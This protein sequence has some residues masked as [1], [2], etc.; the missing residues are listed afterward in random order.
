MAFQ[1]LEYIKYTEEYSNECLAEQCT[2]FTEL[3]NALDNLKNKI[4]DVSYND[5]KKVRWVVNKF[6]FPYNPSII[7]RAFYKFWEILHAFDIPVSGTN[8]YCA[9]APGGFIQAS[10]LYNEKIQSTTSNDTD[11]V[12]VPVKRK[13]WNYTISLDSKSY[14]KRIRQYTT[15]MNGKGDIIDLTNISN[16]ISRSNSKFSMIT[17]DGG[18]DDFFITFNKENSHRLLIYTEVLYALKLQKTNGYFI[19]KFFDTITMSS[20]HVLY[21]LTQVYSEVY[22]MKPDTSRPTNSEKYIVCKNFNPDTTQ[23]KKITDIMEKCISNYKE[24]DL[25]YIFKQ[26][27]EKFINTIRALNDDFIR[28]QIMYLQ[29][30]LTIVSDENFTQLYVE[31]YKKLAKSKQDVYKEWC[32]R[33]NFTN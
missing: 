32:I 24:G 21:L 6:E 27:P 19:L 14:D 20:I 29:K 2:S 22:V 15:V 25:L 12:S 23:L 13:F 7:N 30:A 11:F 16:I 3:D 4:R 31:R 33:N 10:K 9:E 1:K 8:L 5:W 18:L 26:V 17:A 28:N